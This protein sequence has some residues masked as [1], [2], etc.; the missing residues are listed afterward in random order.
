[1][2]IN[3]LVAFIFEGGHN[4]ALIDIR[5]LTFRYDNSHENIFDNVSFQIDTNWKLGFTGRNGR[6]KTTFLKLL[7]GK[8]E[9][10]GMIDTNY[11][12][13]YF[14]YDVPDKT[15]Y[16]IEVVG[17]IY[18][19][20]E[21]WR[22]QKELHLLQVDPEVL[23]RPFHTLSNGQ[24]TKVLLATLFLQTHQYLLIDEP[25][26]HLDQEGREIVS[27]YLKNK[28]GYILVSHDRSFMDGCIDHI[29]AIN[30]TNIEIQSGNFSSWYQ[31]KQNQDALEITTNEKLKKDIQR[32]NI[33][34]KR[35]ANWS[36]KVE[37]T[38]RGTRNSGLRPDTGHIGH[39]SAKMMQRAKNVEK[40]QH[41]AI[42]QKSK[43]LKNIESTEELKIHTLPFFSKQLVYLEN[44]SLYYGQKQVCKD[45]SFTVEQGDRIAL[46]G[47][48]GCGKSSVLK[49]IAG[50]AI[51]YQGIMHKSNQLLIAKVEQDT[52]DLQGTLTNFA[53]EKNVDETLFKTIL[54]KLDFSRNQFEKNIE[55]Y[56]EGQKKKVL[57]AA[58]LAKPAHLYIFDEPLNFIDVF[59]RI[60][61]ENVL[62]QNNATIIFVEHDKIFREKIA[63][64]VITI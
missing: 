58:T 13:A 57:I 64:K 45:I 31:N 39:K 22:L 34:S 24:Q 29:L 5:N 41:K 33:A 30:K 55:T 12:F 21:D 49:L 43:L 9:Y 44:I 50:E 35:T 27:H 7:L 47:V 8:F 63:T 2:R 14:P 40:R 11:S 4:M 32:L 54:R 3:F 28:K 61:I 48:N 23:Y 52:S 15:I 10:S 16:T 18:P 1:M 25:T 19:N 42:E 26:N 56:S 36:D 37:K 46:C 60:Q 59:S 38:K 53:I 20:Y 62:L 51:E 17:N 6:G